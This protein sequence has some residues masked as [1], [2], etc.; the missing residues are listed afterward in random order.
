M[1][2]TS[3]SCSFEAEACWKCSIRESFIKAVILC[4][5]HITMTETGVFLSVCAGFSC[6]SFVW[7]DVTRTRHSI[8]LLLHWC[9]Q[10]NSNA[11]DSTPEPCIP[12]SL[13]SSRK[14]KKNKDKVVAAVLNGDVNDDDTNF[15]LTSKSKAH[16]KIR[17]NPKIFGG[18]IMRPRWVWLFLAHGRFVSVYKLHDLPIADLFLLINYMICES[19]SHPPYPPPPQPP[20]PSPPHPHLPQAV[21]CSE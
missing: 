6:L 19:L 1:V 4:E 11:R 20:R 18:D 7:T 16:R 2:S 5:S 3:R 10:Q 17:V 15:E 9:C 14:S 21:T 12:H 8:I 13:S